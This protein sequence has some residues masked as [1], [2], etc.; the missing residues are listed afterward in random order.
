MVGG[1]I[2]ND[3]LEVYSNLCW[4]RMLLKHL[5]HLLAQRCRTPIALGGSNSLT[6]NVVTMELQPRGG[7]V[8]LEL[9]MAAAN[10]LHLAGQNV[11]AL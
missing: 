11:G 7:H 5:C 3:L 9:E 1:C 2:R 4:H 8:N 10:M 6:I